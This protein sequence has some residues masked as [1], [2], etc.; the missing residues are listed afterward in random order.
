MIDRKIA[1]FYSIYI[2]TR[3]SS[4]G[5]AMNQ[6]G[7]SLR[8]EHQMLGNVSAD[9]HGIL[10]ED[11]AEVAITHIC[12]DANQN[13]SMPVIL[14]HGTYSK[15]NFW[16]SPKGIG[17][18]AFLTDQG[19]DVWI[20]ELR[21]HGHS[22]KGANFSAVTA[23]QQIRYD[24]PAIQHFVLT[25]TR[26][27]TVWI[28]HSFGGVYAL[29]ALAANW[30]SPDS[31]RGMITFGSQISQGERFLKFPPL[32]WLSKTILRLLGHFPAPTFGMGPE[33]EP[34]ATMIEIIRWKSFRGKWVNSDGTSYW[35]GLRKVQVPLCCFAAAADRNDPPE[36]CRILFDHIG[37]G[38]KEFILLGRLNGFLTDYD[39]VGMIISRESQSEIWPLIAN[40]LTSMG[41]T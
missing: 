3:L 4:R 6:E 39:H 30:L 1:F 25:Q 16:I 15:R 12:R 14:L 29:A 19:F 5:A 24:I 41:K 7:L 8:S 17:L 28:C 23:E 32:A 9:V 18:G 37:G 20:P 10:T 38:R 31:I 26:L 11:Q 33:I 27:P 13:K 40:K 35:E 2:P 34:A 22:P 36:G 21:G